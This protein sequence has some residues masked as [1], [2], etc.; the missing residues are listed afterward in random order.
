[1]LPT[2]RTQGEIGCVTDRSGATD[3]I[4]ALISRDA[5]LQD[6]LAQRARINTPAARASTE[7]ASQVPKGIEH[8]KNAGENNGR[9]G[10]RTEGRKDHQD[11]IAVTR[12]GIWWGS[13]FKSSAKL[14]S[15]PTAVEEPACLLR[16][17]RISIAGKSFCAKHYATNQ[18][19]YTECASLVSSAKPRRRKRRREWR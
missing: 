15:V 12:G 11:S 1:M 4:C 8:A 3:G 6:S 13:I 5:A 7:G 18:L 10:I 17:K 16:R 19:E 2:T 14:P 9:K